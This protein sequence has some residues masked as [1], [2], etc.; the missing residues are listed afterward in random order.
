MYPHD[1]SEHS[2]D[3]GEPQAAFL[4]PQKPYLISA[5]SCEVPAAMPEA[6]PGPFALYPALR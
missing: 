3:A 6:H 4:A 1:Y 2:A 5:Y